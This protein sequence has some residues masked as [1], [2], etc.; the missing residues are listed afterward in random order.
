MRSYARN[1][2][3]QV[4]ADAKNNIYRL[5]P[6]G[7]KLLPTLHTVNRI[8]KVKYDKKLGRFYIT[9]MTE[10]YILDHLGNVVRS[11]EETSRIYNE[12]RKIKVTVSYNDMLETSKGEVIGSKRSYIFF[13]DSLRIFKDIIRSSCIISADPANDTVWVGSKNGLFAT[14]IKEKKL[15]NLKKDT[16]LSASI[17]EMTFLEK[18]HLALITNG[19]GLL[20]KTGDTTHQITVKEGLLSGFLNHIASDGKR[21]VWVSSTKGVNKIEFDS[22]D[23]LIYTVSKLDERDGLLNKE[24]KD[25]S[26]FN[27]SL[28]ILLEHSVLKLSKDYAFKTAPPV[29]HFRQLRVNSID[30]LFAKD[31]CL[32]NKFNN[33]EI[34]FDALYYRN[35]NDL[36]YN[37]SLDG[38][39]TWQVGKL[40]KT[41]PFFNL[42]PDEY[43][44]MLKAEDADGRVSNVLSYS[45]EIM[46]PWWQRWWAFLGYIGTLL[47]VFYVVFMIRNRRKL[48]KEEVRRKMVEMELKAL[49]S[50][51][52]PHFTF[53]T[54]NSIQHF[55]NANE[56]EE[57]NI[58]I[59][60]FSRLMRMI[61]DNSREE[62]IT[63]EQEMD[64]LRLYLEIEK[65][66]FFGK[67]EFEIEMD[68]EIDE[69]F[70]RIPPMVIQPFAENAIWHG[71][72]TKDGPRNLIIKLELADEDGI[73]CVVEDNGIG[74]KK[75]GENKSKFRTKHKSHGMNITQ[76]R[77]ELLNSMNKN[78]LESKIIDLTDE[79][80]IGRGTRVEIYI[81]IK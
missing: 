79:E 71:L 47:G 25:L 80:G 30:T 29:L 56:P 36:I 68:E 33:I 65:L 77:L 34:D 7:S 75:A 78:K 46:P 4:F 19:E 28:Y 63:I 72:M 5:A 38:G 21:I 57:A 12:A 69:A 66:R 13:G 70:E 74:R 37:Y 45:F 16:L 22:F 51:M 55:I 17:V 50:Q 53:N 73:L 18:K 3:V 58:Y 24:I 49:R 54:M 9:A 42:S 23:P 61:L 20:L 10:F 31:L 35:Q 39:E 44:F 52:N 11:E 15:L 64:A 32:G 6:N 40:S 2:H 81:P 27:D 76:T 1:E 14:S 26:C 67:F 8:Q 59:S 60:K 62:F 41:I 48:E 43:H